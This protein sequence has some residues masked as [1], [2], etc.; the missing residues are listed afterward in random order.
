MCKPSVSHDHLGRHVLIRPMVA[1]FGS[2][3]PPQVGL[4]AVCNGSA[5][6]RSAGGFFP[7]RS[8][9]TQFASAI[10]VIEPAYRQ[11]HMR[12]ALYEQARPVRGPANSTRQ[13]GQLAFRPNSSPRDL[14]CH[15]WAPIPAVRRLTGRLVTVLARQCRHA[16]KSSTLERTAVRPAA[17]T[18]QWAGYT[19]ARTFSTSM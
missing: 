6:S 15:Q 18:C 3:A 10:C 11:M 8:H 16:R 5:T 2:P 4:Y 7:Q 12:A 17:A 19:R 13:D 1:L 9:G 14:R